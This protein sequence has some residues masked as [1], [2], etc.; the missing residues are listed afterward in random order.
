MARTKQIVANSTEA[1][2]QAPRK[3]TTGGVKKPYRYRPGESNRIII[4]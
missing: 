1:G 4:S 3:K 2:E